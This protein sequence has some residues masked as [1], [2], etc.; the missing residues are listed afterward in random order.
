MLMVFLSYAIKAHT[1]VRIAWLPYALYWE[2]N[3]LMLYFRYIFWIFKLN[4][5]ASWNARSIV[6]ISMKAFIHPQTTIRLCEIL[7]VSTKNE[8]RA[9]VVVLSQEPRH[10]HSL[11]S[12]LVGAKHHGW[13]LVGS[14]VLVY[15]WIQ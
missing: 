5:H 13:C 9:S 4:I 14:T 2:E 10:C 1:P 12:W 6:N 3:F 8:T 11:V 7:K 15:W